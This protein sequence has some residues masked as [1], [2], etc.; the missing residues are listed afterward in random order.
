MKKNTKKNP[1]PT[2]DCSEKRNQ[3]TTNIYGTGEIR[4][5]GR[6]GFFAPKTMPDGTIIQK[7]YYGREGD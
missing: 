3:A 4:C 5:Y 7:F 1:S 6:T 2:I